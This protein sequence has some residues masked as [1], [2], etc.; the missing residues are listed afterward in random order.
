MP[1]S[2]DYFYIGMVI[3][4]VLAFLPVVCR[5]CNCNYE[6]DVQ[7]TKNVTMFHLMVDTHSTWLELYAAT[8]NEL[9]DTVYNFCRIAFGVS[10]W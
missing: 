1:E 8:L 4:T 7:F 3:S 6:N 2:M 10:F 9:P 5:F